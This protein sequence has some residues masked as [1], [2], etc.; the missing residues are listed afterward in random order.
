[1]FYYLT[2]FIIHIF[3]LFMMITFLDGILGRQKR[4]VAPLLY[5]SGFIAAETLSYAVSHFDVSFPLYYCS[6]LVLLFLLTLLY[7]ADWSTRILVSVLFPIF[8]FLGELLFVSAY[9]FLNPEI[10]NISTTY[11]PV[12][13]QFGAKLGLFFLIIVGIAFWEKWILKL[14]V[15]K[16]NIS[17]SLI[18]IFTMS[19]IITLPLKTVLVVGDRTVNFRFFFLLFSSFLIMNVAIFQWIKEMKSANKLKLEYKNMEQQVTYQREKYMQLSA[20][21]KNMRSI[22]HDMKNHY[23]AITKYIENQNFDKLRNYMQNAIQQM[24]DCYAGVNT[25]N[26][27]ID[28]F[29]N[30]FK[31]IA[32]ND[33]ISFLEDISI[34]PDKIPLTDYDLCVIIGNLLD[35]AYHA[36][37]QVKDEEKTVKLHIQLNDNDSFIIFEKNTYDRSTYGSQKRDDLEH[38]YGLRNIEKIVAHYHGL[39]QYQADD[40]FT[41]TI[42]IPIIN[43]HS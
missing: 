10:L 32:E 1:M 29:L 17:L 28:S 31:M 35:N 8:T 19:I 6:I 13:L 11:S 38:G 37:S 33:H 22:L 43:A 25:G 26:L 14:K 30:N 2:I 42:I 27:V 4:K 24:E 21:Y 18:P 36:V 12:L 16:Y 7:D 15:M 9:Q 3:N 41:V 34:A 23:F 5:M 39:M 20:N 40:Y